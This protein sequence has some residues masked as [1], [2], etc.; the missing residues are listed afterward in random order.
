[1]DSLLSEIQDERLERLARNISRGASNLNLRIDELLDLSK[2][3]VGMLQLSPEPIDLLPLLRDVGE[4]MAPLA[5]SRGQSLAIRLPT[6]VCFVRADVSRVQQILLN[7]LENAVKFTPKGGK[8]M[9]RATKK[10]GFAVIEVQDTGRGISKEEQKRL[11]EP[12]HRFVSKKSGFGGLGIGLALCKTLVELHSGQIWVKSHPG[13]GST[14]AFSLPLEDGSP[15]SIESRPATKLWKV[16]I[17]EDDDEIVNSIS[18]AFE[19]DWPEAMLIS[20]RMGEEGIELVETEEPDVVILDLGLPDLDGLDVLKSIR[21]FSQVPVV[22]LTVRGEERDVAKGLD[23]GANDY[24]TK[25]FRKRE[26][27]SRLKAQL[28]KQTPPDEEAPIVCGAL[29]LDTSTCQLT[30]GDREISLTVV[31]G[32]ILEHLMRNA[33]HV[34][35]YSRLTEAVW[36]EDYP[37][38]IESLRVYIGYLRTKLEVDPKKPR[39]IRTKAGVGYSL[40]KP[41]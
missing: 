11:F 19:K 4:S 8:I 25:P 35:T 39:M 1:V 7:L 41:Q 5:E 28:R 10:D 23:V 33:G 40:I 22:V 2:G 26:L 17:I 14:F 27:L 38:A 31:E 9:L 6:S 18:L 24:I 21:L 34:T 36:G 29:S 3:E 12:Y 37:G 15:E 20:T 30:Y 32:R 16:L 13:K